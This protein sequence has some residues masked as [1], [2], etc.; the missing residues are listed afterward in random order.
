MA[1]VFIP[2]QL[3]SLTQGIEQV[4]LDVRNVRQVIEQL[5]DRFPGV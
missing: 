3:R 1:I 2:S 5:E 4:Q